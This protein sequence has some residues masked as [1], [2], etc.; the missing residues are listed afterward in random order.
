A[1]YPEIQGWDWS[2]GAPPPD[3]CVIKSYD[4]VDGKPYIPPPPWGESCLP[5]C[6]DEM[7]SCVHPNFCWEWNDEVQKSVWDMCMGLFDEVRDAFYTCMDTQ[8]QSCSG[9]GC[10]RIS[11]VC[12]LEVGLATNADFEA[13]QCKKCNGEWASWELKTIDCAQTLGTAECRWNETT[14]MAASQ[15]CSQGCFWELC[16]DAFQE[17]QLSGGSMVD[18]GNQT[19]ALNQCRDC[20][21]LRCDERCAKSACE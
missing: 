20:E 10:L 7:D 4:A 12:Q 19:Q 16:Q 2:L 5:A 18:C 21:L 3:Y 1:H 9:G 11:Q 14:G 8:R 13:L 17:C 15:P 6:E